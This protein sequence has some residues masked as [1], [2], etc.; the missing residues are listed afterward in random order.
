MSYEETLAHIFS[1]GRFGIKPSLERIR[2]LLARL[3]DP[4]R[5][6]RIVHIAGT[7]GK[8]STAAFTAAIMQAAG[9]RTGLYTSPH[10]VRFTERM[11]IDGVEIEQ[12]AV[13]DLADRVIAAAPPETTFFELVTAMAF[14]HFAECNVDVAVMEAGMGGRWDATNVADGAVSVITP[15]SLDHCAYLGSTLAEIAAEKA[16]IIKPGG[17]AVIGPQPDEVRVEIGRRLRETGSRARWWGDDFSA[18][19][20]GG[21]M[22]FR[23]PSLSL[24]GMK[25]GLVGSYQSVNA[26]CAVAAV[27]ALAAAGLTVDP[28]H[29]RDG[30]AEARWPGRMELIGGAPPVLLDGAHNPAGVAALKE[31]LADLSFERLLLVVGVMG[32]KDVTGLLAPLLPLADGIFAVAPAMERAL[33]SS[34]LSALCAECSTACTDAGSVAAGLAAARAA[35]ATTDLILVCGSLFTVGEARAVLLGE[36]VDL[37]RI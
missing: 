7:N 23:S 6:L 14:V 22:A 37:C 35:A 29:I 16:G 25:S 11:R 30:V 12:W 9:L 13:V 3:G 32:D 21:T 33:P 24:T 34:R 17:V 20:D 28:A 27:E 18:R 5:A 19:W 2:A 1:R 26:A 31:A 36:K 10:L 8:G 15:I 4:H